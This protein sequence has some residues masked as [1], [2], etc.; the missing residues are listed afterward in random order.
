MSIHGDLASLSLPELLQNLEAQSA[1]GTLTVR[2]P[3]AND[4]LVYFSEGKISLFSSP[5]RPPLV[6]RLVARGV[7]TPAQLESAR[8]KRRGS[9]KSLVQV[10]SQKGIMTIKS[11]AEFAHQT[12]AEDLCDYLADVSVGEF[13]FQKGPP[14]PR[15]FDAEERQ[16]EVRVAVGPLLLEG[17]RRSD[18]WE[19]IRERVPSGQA[20]YIPAD[21]NPLPE[22]FP[23][24]ELSEA[25]LARLD[26]YSTVLEVAKQLPFSRF[27]VFG[28]VANL[29][30]ELRIRAASGN[31]LLERAQAIREESPEDARN[32]L[33]RALE[34]EPLH[35]GLLDCLAEVAERLGRHDEAANCRKAM[36]HRLY[37]QGQVEECRAEL[38]KA[39]VLQPD[40]PAILEKCLE[41]ALEHGTRKESVEYGLKLATLYRE[42]GFPSKARDILE[43]LIQEDEYYVSVIR[44]L[45]LTRVEEEEPEAAIKLL[46]RSGKRLVDRERDRE[47]AELFNQALEI[48]PNRREALDWVGKINSKALEQ[49]RRRRRRLQRAAVLALLGL[50]LGVWGYFETQARVAYAEANSEI[51]RQKWIEAES[52]ESAIDAL[53]R[54]RKAYPVTAT[55][56]FDIRRRIQDFEQRSGELKP[57]ST[58]PNPPEDPSAKD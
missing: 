55:A 49:R 15:V 44:E 1:S 19:L 29:V 21:T 20:Y 3:N 23:D 11:A 42:P 32:M 48:D 7:I 56:L 53:D 25:V 16:L 17:A 34:S 51:S 28:A 12:L 50:S 35:F 45:A 41:R 39:R 40:S 47:A 4:S 5:G 57:V 54:V 13:H 6:E 38:E 30:A 26:G 36:A 33:V 27:E 22:E 52:Y 46:L 9:G 58:E 24:R 43:K 31:D 18:H 8:K 14:P 2:P 37:E 10:F